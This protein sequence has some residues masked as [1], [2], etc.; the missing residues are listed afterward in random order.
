M[1]RVLGCV[2]GCRVLIWAVL[3]LA[4]VRC[5]AAEHD[6]ESESPPNIFVYVAD[7]FGVADSSCYGSKW[8][9]TPNIDRLAEEGTKFTSVF[10]GSPTCNPSRSILYTGLMSARTGAHPNHGQVRSG[11]KS[12]A[13]YMRDAGY[14]VAVVNKFHVSPAICFPFE[15]VKAQ[16]KQSEGGGG[17]I[18]M[19]KFD[20]WLADHLATQPEQPLCVFLCDN[21]THLIWPDEQIDSFHEIDVPA[22][23]PRHDATRQSLGR[24]Y[25]EV[26]L[27]D[28][29]VGE[30]VEVLR[31]HGLFDKSLFLF[32]AD[33]GPAWLHAK[34]TLYDLGLHVPFI[35]RWP[36]KV[37]VG[38][39]SDALISFADVTPTLVE[40]GGGNVPDDLDGQSMVACL[41]DPA[42]GHHQEIY[43]THTGDGT[44]NNYPSRCIRT[45]QFKF[46]WNLRS[47]L[48]YTTHLTS[49]AGKD[50]KALWD[51][52][53]AVR[54][55]NAQVDA[56]MRA[57]QFRPEFELYDLRSDPMELNNLME[58]EAH[59]ELATEMR[60]KL[61][62][63]MDSQGDQRQDM[64]HFLQQKKRKN[65]N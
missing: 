54:N 46:I 47:D 28:E 26:E 50:R 19:V 27:L 8:V 33:Q 62:S 9:N 32:T 58:S 1:S 30:A 29:R 57:Y 25:R 64:S 63:W 43:A 21:N 12:L 15:Q 44:M 17:T 24:Y 51:A 38:K 18:D 22:C 49:A 40:L 10:A 23:L 41:F 65:R 13:H 48:K 42:T 39:S 36:G 7:D 20:T 11:T 16:R 56:A 45:E 35:A 60:R 4:D 61:E 2:K 5:P 55:S 59:Q 37:Q 31:K 6:R 14:R 3:A 52:W 34:W 53:E